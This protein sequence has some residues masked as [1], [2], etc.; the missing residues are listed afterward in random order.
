MRCVLRAVYVR[1]L[2]VR[3]EAFNQYTDYY[4]SA[5]SLRTGPQSSADYDV[6][7]DVA[8]IMTEPEDDPR[9]DC[10]WKCYP[11]HEPCLCAP[12]GQPEAEG[13]AMSD[14]IN[15]LTVVLEKDMRDDDV[16]GLEQAIRNL[17]G[18]R[19]VG[20]NIAMVDAFV[21]YERARAELIEALW[22]VLRR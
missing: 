18:V 21:A 17:R 4:T 16:R 2:A 11:W 1:V 22:E 13:D 20:R 12:R 10:P 9:E 6:F 5:L 7:R 14:R 15:A 3:A 19:E 8:G